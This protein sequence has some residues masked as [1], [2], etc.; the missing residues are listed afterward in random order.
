[1]KPRN[2]PNRVNNRRIAALEK[3]LAIPE[4]DRKRWQVVEIR[5]LRGRTVD[6]ARTVRT[7]KN[8]R[9]TNSP[10]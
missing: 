5:I 9:A 4:Q 2:F 10:R 7:K 3:L 1:M 6:D 8:R